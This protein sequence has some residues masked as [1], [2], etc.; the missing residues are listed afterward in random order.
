M[1]CLDPGCETP[2]HERSPRQPQDSKAHQPDDSHASTETDGASAIASVRAAPL[3]SHTIATARP[4]GRRDKPPS[5][6]GDGEP[7]KAMPDAESD[8]A[9]VGEGR[10]PGPGGGSVSDKGEICL[11][12]AQLRDWRRRRGSNPAVDVDVES[13]EGR[14]EEARNGVRRRI[15]ERGQRPREEESSDDGR[16]EV[17]ADG[18]VYEQ[19]LKGS[20]IIHLREGEWQAEIR[21]VPRHIMNQHPEDETDLAEKLE[22]GGSR[23]KDE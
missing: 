12:R 1:D 21:S 20:L 18:A 22:N 7:T 13:E 14:E 16:G 2:R 4:P 23:A 5:V 9:A 6:G 17:D 10:D 11:G 8:K 19:W 15:A 3:P